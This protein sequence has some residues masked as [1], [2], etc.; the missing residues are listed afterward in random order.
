MART[1]RTSLLLTTGVGGM[2]LILAAAAYGDQLRFDRAAQWGEWKFPRSAVRLAGNSVEP[3]QFHKNVN[4]TLNA[5]EFGG[6]ILKVGSNRFQAAR[7][8]DG[9]ATTGWAPDPDSDPQDW[10]VEIDLGRAV[11]AHRIELLFERAR[12]YSIELGGTL[13]K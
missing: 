13:L 12:L 4:A 3:E 11:T 7:L 1:V 6:G 2:L 8:I 9:D 10:F 5:A